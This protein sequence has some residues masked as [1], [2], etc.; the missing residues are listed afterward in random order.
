MPLWIPSRLANRRV[1]AL[2]ALVL[3]AAG[4]GA[5]IDRWVQVRR[6]VTQ[7]T[8]SEDGIRAKPGPWGEVYYTPFTISAPDEALPVR[9]L[10]A[11]GTH[12]IFP[13]KTVDEVRTLLSSAGVS[14]SAL[15]ALM[16]PT[17]L[18]EGPQGID[19]EPPFATLTD[20]PTAVRRKLYQMLAEFPENRSE[21]TFIHKDTFEERFG[22]SNL[23]ATTLSLF[24]KLCCEHGDYLVF[25]GLGALLAQL[26]TYE[27]KVHFVKALTRQKTM[28]FRLRVGPESDVAALAEYW[29]KGAY[30]VDVRTILQSVGS[31]KGGAWLDIAMLLPPLPASELYFYPIITPNPLDGPPVIRDC[32]WTS[33]NFFREKPDPNFGEPG[34]VLQLL[35]ENYYPAAGDP[36]YG[37]VVLLT[38]PDGSAVHSAVYL[39]DDIVFTK[40]G[41]TIAYPWM[42]STVSDL[43]KQ[44]SFQVSDGEKLTVSYFRTYTL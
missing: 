5:G 8:F 17:A 43:L 6:K 28:L 4:M 23:S 22:N 2:V 12:W 19:I 40:N 11:K 41:S 13:Q 42:L 39:A 34:H 20:L 3:A 38:K 18:R 36:Q 44:Y 24:Q 37:D 29:G 9:T 30:S 32:H 26:P 14:E 7:G 15:G 27:E 10:E 16:S 1:L 35:R 31:V 33:F 21:I 25:S